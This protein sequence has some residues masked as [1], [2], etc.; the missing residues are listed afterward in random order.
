MNRE[1]KFGAGLAALL[2]LLALAGRKACLLANHGMIAAGDSL[3]D[4]FR[5]A[6]EVE[7]L[8]EMYLHALHAGDPVLLTPEEFQAAQQRFA[9]YGTP[10]RG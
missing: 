4:A 9:G 5:I 6:V 3:A 2:A 8:S 7:T 1:L 10:A